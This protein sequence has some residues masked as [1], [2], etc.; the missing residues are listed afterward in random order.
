MNYALLSVFR[1]NHK[2]SKSTIILKFISLQERNQFYNLYKDALRSKPLLLKDIGFDSNDRVMIQE[3]LSTSNSAIFRK[4]MEFKK[5]NKLYS[6][7]TQNGFVKIK[8]SSNSNAVTILK[9]DQLLTIDLQINKKN[10]RTEQHK[11]KFNS[12]ANLDQSIIIKENDPK[13]LK[14]SNFRNNF[15]NSTL[16][17]NGTVSMDSSI[18]SSSAT[19]VNNNLI[20]QDTP[21]R[22]T[23]T[24]TLDEF[25]IRN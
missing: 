8:P 4:A 17:D 5:D 2:S 10:V 3:S 12:S 24:G 22:K 20:R 9:M 18:N 6:V 16:K 15:L 19:V 14:S 7:Y 21:H 1:I 13:I 23:S 11:R 25:V